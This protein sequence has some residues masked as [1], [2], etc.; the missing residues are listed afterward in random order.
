MLKSNDE[1]KINLVSLDQ[2]YI[3]FDVEQLT[4]A[5]QEVKLR[6]CKN[7]KDNIVWRMRTNVPTRYL[8]NPSRGFIEN[9]EPIT[10]TIEL[11]ENKFHP[12]H[13][14]TLQAIAM[15]DG[16][17]E[18]TIWKHQNTKNCNNIQMIRL[19]LS[20]VL[21]NI[22]MSKYEEENLTMEEENM[23]NVIEHITTTGSGRIIELEKMLH[24]LEEDFDN[25]KRNTERTKRL[26]VILEQALD[27]RKLTLIELK[28]RLMECD[29][30][31]K[32][33][34]KELKEKEMKLRLAQQ[35]QT[36]NLTHQICRII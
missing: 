36:N 3:C 22:E 35:I 6:R 7:V 19:K 18:R 8:I 20:T 24:N 2:T 27:S 17:N 16:C 30:E 11:I 34:R 28:R 26:K 33:L 5:K 12:N 31:T 4:N 15:I 23:K 1:Q 9:D 13:K 10:L 25:V 29:Q 32:K 14:L 21:M